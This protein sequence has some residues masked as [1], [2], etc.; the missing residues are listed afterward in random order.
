MAIGAV[1]GRYLL[2]AI[3]TA[4][5]RLHGA[6]VNAQAGGPIAINRDL[7]LGVMGLQVATDITEAWEPA[8][9]LLKLG[10]GFEQGVLIDRLQAVLILGAALHRPHIHRR[11]HF[12]KAAQAWNAIHHPAQAAG[13]PCR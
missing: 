11:R 12:D 5:G 7:E 13:Q 6:G 8:Q 3:G 2:V 10:R 9:A 1:D 4:Q